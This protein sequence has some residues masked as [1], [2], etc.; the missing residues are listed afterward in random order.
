M[1]FQFYLQG[2]LGILIFFK[3][4]FFHHLKV[5]KLSNDEKGSGSAKKAL[6]VGDHET[7]CSN[8]CTWGTKSMPLVTLLGRQTRKGTELGSL[9]CLMVLPSD[10][11][12]AERCSKWEKEKK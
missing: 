12:E 3:G 10:T 11:E 4:S 8:W 1:K 2:N 5:I 7:H 9:G 6:R